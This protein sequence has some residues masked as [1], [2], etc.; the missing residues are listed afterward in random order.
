M[1]RGF[2]SLSSGG[3]KSTATP[4]CPPLLL[5]PPASAANS[6]DPAAAFKTARESA[7]L[8]PQKASAVDAAALRSVG[9]RGV[10]AARAVRRDGYEVGGEARDDVRTDGEAAQHRRGGVLIRRVLLGGRCSR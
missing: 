9:V 5:S 6:E 7:V 10:A 4:Q 2:R 8:T 1:G 3:E